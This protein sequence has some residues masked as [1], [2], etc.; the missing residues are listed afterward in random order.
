MG[1]RIGTYTCSELGGL[2]PM[3]DEAGSLNTSSS[4][5]DTSLTNM[6]GLKTRFSSLRALEFEQILPS[7]YG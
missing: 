5:G 2:L 4:K 1:N 3:T 6:P 7:L